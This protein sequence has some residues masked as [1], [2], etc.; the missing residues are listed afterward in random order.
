MKP[1]RSERAVPS[2][3]KECDDEAHHAED[4]TDQGENGLLAGVG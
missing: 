4:E 2:L 1:Q 3:V